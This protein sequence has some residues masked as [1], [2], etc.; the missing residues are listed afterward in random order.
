[1]TVFLKRTCAF[2]LIFSIIIFIIT[3]FRE[4]A[5]VY[6]DFSMNEIIKRNQLFSEFIKNK[7][8]INLILGSSIAES[9]IDPI[10]LGPKWFLFSNSIQNIYESYVFLN[11]YKDSIK[12]D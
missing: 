1:M 5:I 11:H 8:S 3:N 7:K 9:A 12:I 4:E 2:I 6:D 10:S